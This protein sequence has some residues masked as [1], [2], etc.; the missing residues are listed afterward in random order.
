MNA[1]R[2]Y[3]CM[4]AWGA[5]SI[6]PAL[7]M[8]WGSGLGTAATGHS[9]TFGWLSWIGSAILFIWLLLSLALLKIALPLAING[10]EGDRRRI[11]TWL[12]LV[13][14]AAAI[15]FLSGRV[16]ERP[17]TWFLASAVLTILPAV[18]LGSARR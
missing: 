13:I 4:C 5:T 11:H 16:A 15:M 18:W 7:V 3:A 14:I 12:G 17:G 8:R 6:G 2:A 10:P 1:R 9:G